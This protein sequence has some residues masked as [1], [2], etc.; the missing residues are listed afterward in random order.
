MGEEAVK[1][2]NEMEGDFVYPNGDTFSGSYLSGPEGIKRHGQGK[3]VSQTGCVYDGEW[4]N[5]QI[6]GFGNLKLGMDQNMKETLLQ[7][8]LNI[9]DLSLKISPVGTVLSK[10]QKL[11]R[12]GL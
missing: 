9:L 11:G 1:K 6:N 5:D 2:E 3:W 7:M 12:N 4:E 10:I 8:V